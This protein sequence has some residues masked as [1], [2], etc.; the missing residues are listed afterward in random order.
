MK[1]ALDIAME[2]FAGGNPTPK[3]TDEQK[4]KIQELNN[5][6][7]AKIAERETFLTSRIKAAAQDGN[8]KEVEELQD[9]L[10]RDLANFHEE[11]EAKKKK[12]WDGA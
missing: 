12:V 6:Y 4:Q 10:R 2:R 7:Q 9:Q 3:L 11:L 1:S 5:F 8:A